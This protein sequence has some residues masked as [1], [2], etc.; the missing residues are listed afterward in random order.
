MEERALGEWVLNVARRVGLP[1]LWHALVHDA[2][3]A[4]DPDPDTRRRAGEILDPDR[5]LFFR[6]LREKRPVG[7]EELR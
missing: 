3:Q 7:A 5:E 2:E 6:I 4:G 1:R